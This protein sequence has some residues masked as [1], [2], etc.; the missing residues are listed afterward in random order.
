M[1]RRHRRQALPYRSAGHR[2]R[3]GDGEAVADQSDGN[4]RRDAVGARHRA[5]GR[6]FSEACNALET[7]RGKR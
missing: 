3:E 7:V 1:I 6:H 2:E 4:Q 5:T